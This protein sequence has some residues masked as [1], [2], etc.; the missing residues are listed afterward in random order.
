LAVAASR[1][2]IEPG[3]GAE[4]G[5]VKTRGSGVGVESGRGLEGVIAELRG[6]MI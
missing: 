6:K 5:M 1:P 4:S 2:E 3:F